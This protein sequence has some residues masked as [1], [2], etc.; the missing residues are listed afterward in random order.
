MPSVAQLATHLAH[1]PCSAHVTLNWHTSPNYCRWLGALAEH[2]SADSSAVGTVVFAFQVTMGASKVLSGRLV[3]ALPPASL[4]CGALLTCG[5]CSCASAALAWALP[6]AGAG[7]PAT[8]LALGVLWGVMGLAQGVGWGAL[9]GVLLLARPS[10]SG[11][12]TLYAVL[13]ASQNVGAAAVPL[14]LVPV[15]AEWKGGGVCGNLARTSALWHALCSDW[16]APLALPGL[17]CMALSLALWAILAA[18]LP[19]SL[20]VPV[21][22]S[23]SAGSAPTDTTAAGTRSPLAD[24]QQWLLAGGYFC[25]SFVRS[26]LSTWMLVAL[27]VWSGGRLGAAEA[28]AALAAVETGGF[29]GSWAAGLASDTWFAGRRAP[30]MVL[31]AAILA[32]GLAGIPWVLGA[33]S[34]P[35]GEDTLPAAAV[36]GVF[37]VVGAGAFAWHMLV[38][39]LS[40]ELAPPRSREVAGGF[41]KGVAQAG[42]AVGAWPAAAL[43]VAVGWQTVIWLLVTAAVLSGVCIAPLL[44]ARAPAPSK[45][46]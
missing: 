44:P 29:L 37:G 12:G 41:V 31:A 5:A 36:S 10:P 39:L 27:P 26:V 19:S 18:A 21:P 9:V 45:T 35:A 22:S 24:P 7:S 15:L 33:G 17:T 42:A 30:V 6:G 23:G 34:P 46:T 13:S 32:A 2:L 25:I 11:R 40:R 14:A 38:G 8:L 4:L 3:T 43:A 1:A 16:G 20:Q 28:A